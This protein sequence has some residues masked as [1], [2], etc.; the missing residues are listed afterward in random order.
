MNKGPLSARLHYATI[1][2]IELA[3]QYENDELICVRDI[4][5]RHGIPLPFLTQIL[6]QLRSAGLVQSTRGATGGYKL[7][8]SPEQITMAD[9]SAVWSQCNDSVPSTNNSDVSQVSSTLWLDAQQNTQRYLEG[10]RL[11]QLLEQLSEANMFHI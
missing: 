7:G 2:M 10:V 1:A 3:L 8:R 9:I 5:D 11:D 4:A 6:H